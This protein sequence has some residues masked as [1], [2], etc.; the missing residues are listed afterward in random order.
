MQEV[1]NLLDATHKFVAA[2]L[3][4]KQ[5]LDD[6]QERFQAVIALLPPP[7]IIPISDTPVREVTN[8]QTAEEPE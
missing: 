6:L 8:I 2:F 4:Q 7:A 1:D 3:E 5:A